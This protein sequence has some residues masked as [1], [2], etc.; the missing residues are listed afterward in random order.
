M[1]AP[2]HPPA[3]DALST[4]DLKLPPLQQTLVE[5][6][7]LMNEPEG[8]SFEA[9]VELVQRDPAATTRLL[10]VAN[11]PFYGQ[12][13]EVTS[14]QRAVMLMGMETALAMVLGLSLHQWNEPMDRA[15]AQAC[16]R[17]LRH[18]MATAFLARH[19]LAY[20]PNHGPE[21]D[22]LQRDALTA[23]LLHDI[24]KLVLLYNHRE[25]A[26]EYYLD[27][28]VKADTQVAFLD[29]ERAAFGTD[30]P[31]AG[32]HLGQRLKLPQT[33]Q[34]SILLHH[35]VLDDPAGAD[36]GPMPFIVAAADLAAN[37]LGFSLNHMGE[38]EDC[39]EHPIWEQ[40]QA[41]GILSYSGA[42][43]T[44]QAAMHGRLRDFVESV[45]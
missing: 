16:A 39:Q 42:E 43:T 20:D 18:S 40:L 31:A 25:Q 12:R 15:T 29:R 32:V 2:T 3:S 14:V 4:L 34:S 30:H 17:L 24:G 44:L 41:R 19:L 23:A 6:A 5:A 8:P 21:H 9:I 10:Q 33:V 28:T 13:R 38:W 1:A 45:A 27:S 11:S 7:A 37:A 22:D 36:A 26:A 35:N